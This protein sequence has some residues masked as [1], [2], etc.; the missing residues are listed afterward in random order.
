M[1]F[2]DAFAAELQCKNP[3]PERLALFIAGLDSPQPEFE[4]CLK[5]IEE[6]AYYGEDSLFSQ[7]A[8]YRR[9]AHFLYLMHTE[10]GFKGNR[11]NYYDPYNSFLHQVLQR[12]RGLPITLSVLYMA[13]GRHLGMQIE[14]IGFPGHFMARYVDDVGS[15]LLDPFH[16]DILSIDAAPRHLSKLFGRPVELPAAA[17]QPLAAPTIA[18]R[19]LNNLYNIYLAG[20]DHLLTIRVLDYMLVLSPDNPM[21]WR[22][23]GLL[24]HK[25][26]DWE[27]A[28]RDLRRYFFLTGQLHITLPSA[29]TQTESATDLSER[30]RGLLHVLQ[31]AE[32]TRTRIN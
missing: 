11:D 25:S 17:Y 4:S 3:A 28:V 21:L 8:G 20:S 30:D 15:W 22:E 5:R 26:E 1:D 24:H 14:G 10:L 23:R 12:R 9:A 19:I 32:Q 16:G 29:K 27:A 7:P 13:V 6:I 18:Q 2:L 31:Q